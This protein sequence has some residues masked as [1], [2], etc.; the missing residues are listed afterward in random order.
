MTAYINVWHRLRS[1]A[2]LEL[3]RSLTEEEFER[4]KGFV[5]SRT[6]ARDTLNDTL[7][8]LEV[9]FSKETAATVEEFT[10]WDEDNTVRRVTELP[11]RS[12]FTVWRRRLLYKVQSE[13]SR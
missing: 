6:E 3:E 13:I 8:S 11:P 2:E 1:I 7:C 4:K 9:Y 12:E 5:A 10:R